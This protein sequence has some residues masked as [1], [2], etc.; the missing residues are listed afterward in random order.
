[1][2]AYI[3]AVAILTVAAACDFLTKKIPNLLIVSGYVIAF[4]T[5]L[6]LNGFEDYYIYFIRAL[7]PVPALFIFYYLKALG[8]GDIKLFSVISIFCPTEFLIRFIILSFVIAAFW[9]IV[10]LIISKELH[11]KMLS[12]IGHFKQCMESGELSHYKPKGK[13]S[14]ICFS[15]C[16]LAAFILDIGMEVLF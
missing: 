5:M 6:I 10:K 2:Q 14:Y 15:V 8:A 11:I 7:W 1:M 3:V 16:M 4:A 12:L 9:G 13:S